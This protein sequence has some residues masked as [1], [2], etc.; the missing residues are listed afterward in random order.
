M[1]PL[2]RGLG[3]GPVAA[4]LHDAFDDFELGLCED[5]EEGGRVRGRGG[6]FAEDE[7]G[8]G[9]GDAELVGVWGGGVGT[10]GGGWGC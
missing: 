1:A 10:G 8:A 7:G 2:P 9:V 6:V 5:G 3:D 4:R